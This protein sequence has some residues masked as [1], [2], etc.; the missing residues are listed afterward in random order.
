[1]PHSQKTEKNGLDI[2]A[3]VCYAACNDWRES[4]ES[5]AKGACQSTDFH[6]PPESDS[7]RM[8][9]DSSALEPHKVHWLW[10]ETVARLRRLD[11]RAREGKSVDE[12]NDF[13][14]WVRM[15]GLLWVFEAFKAAPPLEVSADAVRALLTEIACDCEAHWKNEPRGPW[16]EKSELESI[17]QKLDLIAGQLVKLS[18]PVNQET[19]AAG[20]A[21]PAL[22][23]IEGGVK[24]SR[25]SG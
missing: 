25:A 1:M 11:A 16:V 20:T 5:P 24:C 6:G 23:V 22:R 19:A 12:A 13:A 10:K 18:P 15:S 7:T 14:R 3:R 2:P 21:P 8:Q 9:T 17:N 4:A